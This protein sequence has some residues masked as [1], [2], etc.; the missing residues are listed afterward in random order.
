[1]QVMAKVRRGRDVA[2][3]AL[4]KDDEYAQYKANRS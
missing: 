1:M 2:M 3:V 4:L